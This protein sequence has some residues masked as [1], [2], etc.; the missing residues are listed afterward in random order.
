MLREAP[1]ILI[2]ANLVRDMRRSTFDLK[3]REDDIA[4]NQPLAER[5][6]ADF[7]ISLP[8]LPDGEDWTAD[9]YFAAVRQPLS[10]TKVTRKL[11]SG[12]VRTG[13]IPGCGGGIG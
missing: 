12:P 13:G 5:L 1:L 11:I 9:A 7:G 2:P 4:I 3:A 10:P 8:P 6:Q